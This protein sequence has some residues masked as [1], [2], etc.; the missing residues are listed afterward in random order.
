ML[1]EDFRKYKHLFETAGFPNY[2]Q[3]SGS[4]TILYQR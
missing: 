4:I 1:I 3:I 2:R